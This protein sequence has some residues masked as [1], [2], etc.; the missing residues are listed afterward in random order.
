MVRWGILGCGDV[1]EVKSGPGFQRATGSSLVAVMRRNGDLARDYANRHGVKRWYA[2]AHDLIHDAE[3]DA[4]YIATPP[5]SHEEL[6]LAVAQAGKPAYVEK[7]MARHA[8]ECDQMVNTFKTAGLP[9]YVAYYRRALPRFLAVRDLLATGAIGAVSFVSYR[10]EAPHH[11]K[12]AGWRVS[13]ASSGGGHFL[14]VG[15]H[16]LDLIDFLLGP[17]ES[18]AGTARRM[19][20]SAPVEDTISMRFLAGRVGGLAEWNFASRETIDRLEFTGE[21]GSIR[22]SVFG[23][24]PVRWESGGIV[25]ALDR[26]NPPHV[27]EPLIQTVVDDLLGRGVCPST[28][29]SARRT[30]LV[31][32]QVLSGFYGGRNDAFWLRQATWPGLVNAAQ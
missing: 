13:A 27:Q 15:S 4:V 6:T 11:L 7:P 9:L 24:E 17:L 25:E 32:D 10:G 5:G 3:V 14:D 1:T 23:N 26:P 2:N 21:K 28:G 29:E 30:T 20:P 31:M 12:D 19:G 18:V 22:L 16:V 8:P